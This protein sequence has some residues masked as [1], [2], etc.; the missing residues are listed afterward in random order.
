LQQR[1][2]DHFEQIEST[3]RLI[4]PFFDRF[5]LEPLA[6]DESKILLEWKHVG[7]EEYF[8]A[9]SLSDGT[10]RMI[11]L[12][13]LLLQPTLPDTVIIDEPELGLH[14]SAI[15]ILASL[16]ESASL[17]TQVIISTQSVTLINH[18]EPDNI[19]VVE[20]ENHH[21]VFKHLDAESLSTWLEDYSLGE[22]WEKNIIGGRP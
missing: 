15:S 16:V 17:K 6:L 19:I 11:C 14:P 22:M 18:F 7:S 4:A 1:H 20:R 2:P 5:K 13:T 21:S 3:V 12:T 8:N 10:L 9:H